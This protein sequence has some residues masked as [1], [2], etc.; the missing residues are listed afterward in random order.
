[1][2]LV[3]ALLMIYFLVPF[4]WLIVN[5]SK[6]AAGLFGGGSSL[7]FADDVN[8]LSNLYFREKLAQASMVYT[9]S[10]HSTVLSAFASERVV[11]STG[12]ADNSL[13]DSELFALNNNVRQVGFNLAHSYRLD[14]KTS[15]TAGLTATRSRSLD[16]DIVRSQQTLSMGMRQI[17]SRKL[18]GVVELRHARGEHGLAGRHYYANSISATLSAQL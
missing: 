1:M 7:W 3:L 9:W 8:Y 11:L 2:N 17:F 12:E 5:S 18:Q 16:T 6:S 15:A 14:T 4:W 13:I 10:T